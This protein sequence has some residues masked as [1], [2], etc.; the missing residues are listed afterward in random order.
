MQDLE[1]RVPLA[2]EWEYE[3][4][5]RLLSSYTGET[6]RHAEDFDP[7]IY[8]AALK[9]IDPVAQAILDPKAKVHLKD[10]RQGSSMARP[11]AHE[12]SRSVRM[13]LKYGTVT[14]LRK[15]LAVTL[16]V[17]TLRIV[18]MLSGRYLSQ[19]DDE[20]RDEHN[21]KLV[22]SG[23]KCLDQI[24]Q[25]GEEVLEPSDNRNGKALKIIVLPGEKRLWEL[26]REFNMGNISPADNDAPSDDSK[27]LLIQ[28]KLVDTAAP[29]VDMG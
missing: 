16:L 29:S 22:R 1:H 24:L 4:L 20:Q 3:P 11:D 21:F 27:R 28:L 14:E 18:E 6:S 8:D 12:G 17:E 9:G 19:E 5:L 25:K 2:A 26:R 15:E 23:Q 10:E 13:L 7:S